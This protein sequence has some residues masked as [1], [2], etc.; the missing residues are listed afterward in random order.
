[1]VSSP[2]DSRF[3]ASLRLRTLRWPSQ[4]RSSTAR[5]PGG[6]SDRRARF[7]AH[8]DHVKRCSHSLSCASLRRRVPRAHGRP[9]GQSRRPNSIVMPSWT[10]VT[11]RN[12][13]KPRCSSQ[14]H[15]PEPHLGGEGAP[16]RSSGTAP[17]FYG[18]RDRSRS[19][20]STASGD[21]SLS[22]ASCAISSSRSTTPTCNC[23]EEPGPGSALTR[24]MRQA[25]GLGDM[26]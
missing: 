22:S 20:P 4:G 26:G 9:V 12:R 3:P 6:G 24:G 16:V 10:T 11:S 17:A 8:R 13:M 14:H 2:L 23:P 21:R 19:P 7:P 25:V 15:H 18:G 5:L 1:M